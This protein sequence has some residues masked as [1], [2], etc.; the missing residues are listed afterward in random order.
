MS[1]VRVGRDGKPRPN[2][3][4]QALEVDAIEILRDRK[5]TAAGMKNRLNARYYLLLQGWT[6]A[7]IDNMR[8][9][10]NV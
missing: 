9:A 2:G 1:Y 7:D 8:D 10:K 6:P 3:L 4:L 5:A